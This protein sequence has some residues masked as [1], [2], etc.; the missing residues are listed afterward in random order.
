MLTRLIVICTN[1]ESH[2]TPAPNNML[3]QLHNPPPIYIYIYK[4][5]KPLR[6]TRVHNNYFT[7]TRSDFPH[8][9]KGNRHSGSGW[10][11]TGRG[12]GG[13]GGREGA[14]EGG[15]GTA[16]RA[17]RTSV[18]FSFLGST[19]DTSRFSFERIWQWSWISN[20]CTFHRMTA[21]KYVEPWHLTHTEY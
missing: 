19:K 14:M 5:M 1:T 11:L 20:A 21:F 15:Q 13:P 2:W 3:C 7:W 8:D 16:G 10:W 12:E 9:T 4:K 17:G 6:Q 18:H